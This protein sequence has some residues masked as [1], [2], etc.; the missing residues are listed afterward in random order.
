[1]YPILCCTGGRNIV[2]SLDIVPVG[3]HNRRGIF[4]AP[5]CARRR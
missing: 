2:G 5:V 1:M 4:L 3:P